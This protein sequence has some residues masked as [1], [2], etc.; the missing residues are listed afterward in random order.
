MV[1]IFVAVNIIL[2]F[3]PY[4]VPTPNLLFVGYGY[5]FEAY[6]RHFADRTAVMAFGSTPLIYLL[7]SR[8]K[9]V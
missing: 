8:N 2:L 4:D 1:S 6:L 5:N 9:W 3:T 7:A